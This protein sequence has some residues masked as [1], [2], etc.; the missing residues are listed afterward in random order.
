[1][2]ADYYENFRRNWHFLTNQKL[3][4]AKE[5]KHSYREKK[6]ITT[7][8][9]QHR[10]LID[11]DHNITNFMLETIHGLKAGDVAWIETPYFLPRG[12]LNRLQEQLVSAAKRNVDVRILTN[13][14]ESSDFGLMVNASIFD[15]REL[16]KAGARI[17]HRSN[18][19]MLH[20]K[21]GVFGALNK[22]EKDAV[23]TIG[24][25][26]V[27]SKSAA[28]DSE[29]VIAIYNKKIANEMKDILISDMKKGESKE[30]FLTDIGRTPLGNEIKSAAVNIIA[31][32]I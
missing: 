9:V 17:F 10:P 5:I 21:V 29:N 3:K 1:V 23:T 24:S 22:K 6:Q 13:S 20:A 31:E 11:G 27:D 18:Q 7:Q 19:R 14:E 30:I 28:H 32:L 2:V 15:E 26:N 16:L 25:W 8:V 4:P 12:I